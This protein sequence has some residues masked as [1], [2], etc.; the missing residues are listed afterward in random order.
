[1]EIPSPPSPAPPRARILVVEDE[2]IIANDIKMMLESGGYL[3]TAVVATGARAVRKAEADCPDLVLMDIVLPGEL[4]GIQAAQLIRAGQDIPV[5]YLTAY[6]DE[7]IVSR[8]L[9]SEPF[10]Y[11]VKP[12]HE[13]ELFRT[14]EIGLYKHR[15]ERRLRESEQ[16]LS[17]TLRS[18]GEAVVATGTGGLVRF[19]NPAAEELLGWAGEEVVGRPLSEI[20]VLGDPCAAGTAAPQEPD[21]P[22]GWRGDYLIAT[23]GGEEKI[24]TASSAP[25]VDRDRNIL[26]TV[27]ALRDITEK[28]AADA[29][30]H[31]SREELKI[32][33]T[34]VQE[35]NT[36]LK[37]LLEQ[38]ERDRGE[39]EQ[40]IME[41]IRTLIIPYLEK[42]KALRPGAQDA[43]F[44]NIIET[45]LLQ[46]TSG[47]SKKLSSR[48]HNLSMQEI[49][50]AN[51]VKEG[52]HDK[53]I[54]ELLNISFETVKTHRQNIRKKLGIY[55][56]HGG[57][58]SHLSHFSD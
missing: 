12:F 15:L 37:V 31:R 26:G 24:V 16:W 10:G 36:A 11:V 29:E 47:F 5:I 33:I 58:R 19:V 9:V 48:F 22:G 20:L 1:M 6:T 53:E 51:L 45:N 52:K 8:A 13:S 34:E 23:R 57:L 7:S 40:R 4:D 50:I 44:L 27:L 25:I 39:F 35:R 49:R 18:I 46:I 3:V 43:A 56:E 41:N 54:M 38:R 17:T 14:I 32:H 30:L 55:G 42:L 2:A 21:H 28:K